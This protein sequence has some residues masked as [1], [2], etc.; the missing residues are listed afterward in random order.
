M[1]GNDNS[2]IKI[3]L[4]S[5]PKTLGVLFGLTVLLSQAAPAAAQSACFRGP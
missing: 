4:Q 1:S 2:E 5:H 3:Y